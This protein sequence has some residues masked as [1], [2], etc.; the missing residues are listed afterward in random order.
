M[1]ISGLILTL[2][3]NS[4]AAQTALD[5]CHADPQVQVGEFVGP[6]RCPITLDTNN[7]EEDKVSWQRLQ[8]D[9]GIDFVDVV[10]VYFDEDE[11]AEDSTVQVP[12]SHSGTMALAD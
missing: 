2:S 6:R 11:K 5:K 8:D 12:A 1:P 4:E 9:P 10:C 3:S 7:P